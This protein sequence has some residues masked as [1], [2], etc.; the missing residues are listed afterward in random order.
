MSP[1]TAT[2]SPW[3]TSA[4]YLRFT[5]LPPP[6]HRE[7]A[8][9]NPLQPQSSGP[10]P[11][12]RP[13]YRENQRSGGASIHDRALD[14]GVDHLTVMPADRAR[15]MRHEHHREVLAGIRP[16]VGAARAR[17]G[18][19]ADRAERA[20]DPGRGAHREPEPEAIVGARGVGAADQVLDVGTELIGEHV[21]HGLASEDTGVAELALVE[22]HQRETQVIARGRRRAR[23]SAAR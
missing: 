3:V 18:K 2:T 17:P 14:H 21:F 6:L 9:T 22:Q 8:G 20:H 13:R 19:V 1:R 15:R 16:P 11:K 7:D 23:T 10:K 12:L 4:S 5:G